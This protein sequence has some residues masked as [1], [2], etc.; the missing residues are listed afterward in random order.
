MK[1]SLAMIVKNE[2]EVLRE[3]LK[4]VKNIVDEIILVDTGS[5][6]R[7]L[8]IAREFGAKIYSFEWC[9]DFS[10]ARNFA[11]E[12]CTGDW[13]LVLDA[14]EIV[15]IGSKKDL[16]D[17]AK[18]NPNSIGRVKI[19]SKFLDN[20]EINFSNEYVSRFYPK[21]IY[22][23]GYIHEQLDTDFVRIKMKIKLNH[24]GYFKKDKSRRNLDL[25]FKELKVHPNDNYILYQIAKT[26]Y[27]A[28]RYDEAD[29]YF[30][31][32]YETRRDDYEYIRDFI[33]LYIYNI[34]NIRHFSTGLKIIKE[35]KGLFIRFADFNFVCALFYMNLILS[36][37]H[38]F[39]NDINLIEEFYKRCLD[40]GENEGTGTVGVGT[41][42]AAYNLGVFYETTG[43]FNKAKYYYQM[44]SKYNFKLA[45]ERLK[46][47]NNNV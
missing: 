46:V 16:V 30:Q 35:Y 5:E 31:L 3:C 33:V 44:A 22:Y 28:R 6:D 39:Y 25:L 8:E 27:V 43:D 36:D 42:K 47:L 9:Y 18:E 19:C 2:E 45:N 17:F 23:K 13:I 20:G 7:T 34:I 12:K 24:S 32:C 41:F 21:G 4:S 11:A 14:D 26:L 40:I 1:V 15:S 29:R 38:S 37:I 10:A